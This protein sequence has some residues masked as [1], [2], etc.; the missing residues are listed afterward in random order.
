MSRESATHLT[1]KFPHGFDHANS[2]ALLVC[3]ARSS[4]FT[5]HFVVLNDIQPAY[6]KDAMSVRLSVT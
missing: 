3:R 2:D 4:Y 1:L 6:Y 5:M